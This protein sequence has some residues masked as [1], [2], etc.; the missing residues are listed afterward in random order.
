MIKTTKNESANGLGK[1]GTNRN[2]L[3]VGTTCLNAASL[4]TAD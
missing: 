3:W 4:A 2:M 1:G